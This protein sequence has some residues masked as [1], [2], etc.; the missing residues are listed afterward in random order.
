M[1]NPHIEGPI[2][3]KAEWS[4][5]K[6]VSFSTGDVFLGRITKLFSHN[7]ATLSV[8]GVALSARLEAALTTGQSY[9]FEVEEGSGVPR[10]RVIDDN[11]LRQREGLSAQPSA[12]ELIK[13]LNLPNSK[14]VEALLKQFSDQQ[15]PFTKESILSGAQLLSQLNR[16]DKDTMQ[17]LQS[18]IHRQ[19]PLTKDTFQAFQAAMQQ[20][21]LSEQMNQLL[22]EVKESNHPFAQQIGNVVNRFFT[23][24]QVP[25][26]RSP[27]T[28]LLMMYSSN[29]YTDEARQGAQAFL[30]KLGIVSGK[31]HDHVYEQFREA[32]FRPENRA[33]V[34]QLWPN[35][36]VGQG[37]PISSLDPKTLFELMVSR[38]EIPAGKEGV[39]QLQQLLQLFR[40]GLQATQVLNQWISLPNEQLHP[41]ERLAMQQVL[42]TTIS[43][44]K[45]NGQERSPIANHLQNV[46]GLLGYN[47]ENEAT[48][49]LQGDLIRETVQSE[50]LKAT[51]LMMQQQDSPTSIKEKVDQLIHRITGQQ[52]LAQ[53]Q[54]GPL[55]HIALQMPLSLGLFKTDMSMQWEGKK[56][57]DG[58]LDANHC[59]ILFYLTLETLD[60]VIV[61]VQIQNRLMAVTIFNEQDRPDGLVQ[62]LLPSLKEA[63]SSHNYQLSSFTWKEMKEV[64]VPQTKAKDAYQQQVGYQGVDVR[65]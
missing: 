20:A 23:E 9:W 12:Q 21:P 48:R 37:L 32:I 39:P 54:S 2:S 40:P 59:R 30:E 58:Q 33:I 61:D 10:L 29:R 28:E 31:S 15:L 38:L 16:Y 43:Q 62:H 1:L 47:H 56:T 4:S 63:L 24:S 64:N 7:L 25:P 53:E 19:L 46:L 34:Q 11:R 13:Q 22:R 41:S 3:R 57:K 8:N 50:R 36:S 42:E 51:L 27:V 49:L 18:M 5:V 44:T 6:S 26:T 52:L 55:Q 14:A 60:E 35:I 65:I 45:T 17:L